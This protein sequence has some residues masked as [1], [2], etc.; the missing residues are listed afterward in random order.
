MLA[1]QEYPASGGDS[2]PGRGTGG[3][4]AQAAAGHSRA[5]IDRR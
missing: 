4:R 3:S 5:D 1:G 2:Q